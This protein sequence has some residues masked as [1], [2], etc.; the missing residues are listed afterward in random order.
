MTMVEIVGHSKKMGRTQRLDVLTPIDDVVLT[1]HQD[2]V[3][4]RVIDG[5]TGTPLDRFTLDVSGALLEEVYEGEY[6]L[7]YTRG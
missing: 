6:S 3:R 1:L 7:N 2:K 4:G 5:V